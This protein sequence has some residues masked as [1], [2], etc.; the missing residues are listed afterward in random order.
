MS[1]QTDQHDFSPEV[2]NSAWW[3]GDSGRAASGKASEV[4]LQKL[5]I[6]KKTG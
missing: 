2:R 5:G 3:S 6:F 1:Q 4:I